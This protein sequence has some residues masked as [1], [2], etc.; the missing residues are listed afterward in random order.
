M[1]NFF[2]G[3]KALMTIVLLALVSAFSTVQAQ[4]GIFCLAPLFTD[5]MVFQQQ[6]LSPVWG[7]GTPG[8]E[9]SVKASW[10]AKASAKVNADSTWM[11]KI[12][13]PKAGGPF[14]VVVNHDNT[15]LT[16]H[17]VLSGEVW[18]CSGQ[19]NM[20]MPLR[21]WPPLDTILYSPLE[22]E[23]ANRPE[24][25][26]FTV[27]RAF[28]ALPEFS[29]K[30]SW[31]ASSPVN[32]PGFSAT[33]F[34]FGK[35]LYETLHVPIG[36]IH[37]SW[38]GTRIEAWMDSKYLSTFSQ[39]DSLLEKLPGGAE[40][41][42]QITA[43]LHSFPTIDMDARKGND[44][45]VGLSFNDELCPSRS[46]DDTHWQEMKLPTLWE[47]TSVGQFDG[48]VW[49]RKQVT[50]PAEWV[51]KPLVIDLGPVDDIDI[52]YVNGVKV[53]SHEREG[54]YAVKRSYDVPQE[55]ADSTLVQIAVRVIDYGGGGGIWGNPKEMILHPK[56]S[57][58]GVSLGGNWKFEPVAEYF[59]GTLFVFGP[60]GQQFEKRPK[61]PIDL[62]ENTPT[63][64][65]NGMIAPLVPY[66][67]RGTIW[68]QGEANVD[69][70]SLY[71]KLFPTFIENWRQ[72]FG[73]GDFP[74][75][76]VQIA[77]Y[78]YGANSHSEFLRESQLKTLGVKNTGMAVLLDVGNAK[79][80][81]PANKLT[82][83]D[84]LARWAL[85]K[86][87]AKKIVYSGPVYKTMK[88]VKGAIEL[89]FQY[90]DKGLVLV[91]SV[92]GTGFKI[93]GEDHVFKEAF[94][95]VRGN[96]LL[97]SNPDVPNPVAV[98]YDF[99]NTPDATL[100][101]VDGLPASSFRT[102]NWPE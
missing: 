10:G 41:Q 19:S 74:F 21:G 60:V 35:K 37:S 62:S 28:S 63:V 32:A 61:L 71:A 101:N 100:F 33:A 56:G 80:I 68:Y 40:G 57:T 58:E 82:V 76:Y 81:H 59:D 23:H 48:V 47:R 12:R 22:I 3:S 27:R 91:G 85:A 52:T 13:T 86:T 8:T 50:I 97:V 72:N 11:L 96:R 89:S 70:A 44:R 39:Y 67:I 2:R 43:W 30:G 54:A 95:E 16:L 20:E 29:C 46:Y 65:Y 75:Y 93:A 88:L 34:F 77:A 4:Q 26:F 9:V 18:L 99:S 94:V 36:L 87:Y 92:K 7:L 66:A 31:V 6:M 24:V 69:N 102:D 79:N 64:L 5:S 42:R 45:W 1:N 55:L 25:R 78:D 84:R 38:G 51:H 14:E 73:V 83:G 49:F 90:A 15:S 17:N 53:G 98:R